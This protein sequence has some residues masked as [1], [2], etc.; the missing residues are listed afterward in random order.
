VKKYLK[1]VVVGLVLAF[2][3]GIQVCQG[4]GTVPGAIIFAGVVVL[5]LYSFWKR[6]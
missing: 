1:W 3:I 4:R 6:R 5:F 2:A